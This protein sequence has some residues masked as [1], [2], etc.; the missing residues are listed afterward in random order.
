MRSIVAA[1]IAVAASGTPALCQATHEFSRSSLVETHGD[2]VY[3]LYAPPRPAAGAKATI[4]TSIYVIRKDSTV[5]LIRPGPA[6]DMPPEAA[7]HFRALLA[8]AIASDQMTQRLRLL[9]KRP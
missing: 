5:R 4:D 9:Q 1:F 7:K 6:R 8:E 2:T 3:W